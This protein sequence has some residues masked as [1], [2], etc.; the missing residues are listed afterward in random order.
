MNTVLEFHSCFS[1]NTKMKLKSQVLELP[2]TSRFNS[3]DFPDACL[4]QAPG[5]GQSYRTA[6]GRLQ[7]LCPSA[8]YVASGS[9]PFSG[10]ALC[11]P[12]S[13]PALHWHSWGQNLSWSLSFHG[14]EPENQTPIF[15]LLKPSATLHTINLTL[16]LHFLPCLGFHDSVLRWFS[17]HFFLLKKLMEMKRPGSVQFYLRFY[18]LFN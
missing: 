18:L 1:T 15:F 8:H 7:S 17:F 16:P 11:H 10:R 4:S 9:S 3:R 2:K 5:Q 13:V 6:V 14:L 12:A